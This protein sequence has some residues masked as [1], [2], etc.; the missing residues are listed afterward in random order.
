MMPIAGAAVEV[1]MAVSAQPGAVRILI[2]DK[3][4]GIS[5]GNSGQIFAPFFTTARAKG[6]TGLG[7]SLVRS[8]LQSRGG[9]VALTTPPQGFS[10]AFSLA[11]PYAAM[12]KT[13]A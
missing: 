12:R 6:G 13:P 7:L 1:H 10:T 9:S 4:P 2:A 11:I 3:G 5:D 8:H